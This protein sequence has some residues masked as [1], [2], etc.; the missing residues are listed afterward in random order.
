MKCKYKAIFIKHKYIWKIKINQFTNTYSL[1]IALFQKQGLL[2]RIKNKRKNSNVNM[3]PKAVDFYVL[4]WQ[5]LNVKRSIEK[6]EKQIGIWRASLIAQGVQYRKKKNKDKLMTIE[7][8]WTRGM[9]KRLTKL[10]KLL[11]RTLTMHTSAMSQWGKT[12]KMLLGFFQRQRQIQEQY[13]K[14]GWWNYTRHWIES[15]S[16]NS[17]WILETGTNSGAKKNRRTKK[18]TV[19]VG[20]WKTRHKE[21]IM[22]FSW[23]SNVEKS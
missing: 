10:F 13:D 9:K 16:R 4:T 19:V 1:R 5:I 21:A 8:Q 23:Q 20:I 11:I 7:Q 15:C 3:K 17:S 22:M 6:K 12:K 14:R 18:N 2:K